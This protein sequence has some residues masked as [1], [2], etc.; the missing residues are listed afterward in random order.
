MYGLLSTT[1]ALQ[2]AFYIPHT[3]YYQHMN[4]PTTLRHKKTHMIINSSIDIRSDLVLFNYFL[5]PQQIPIAYVILLVLQQ[6]H[7][8]SCLIFLF[9]RDRS[10]LLPLSFVN[11][12]NVGSNCF[13]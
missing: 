12:L 5:T 1:Y 11:L 10:N 6:T 4:F 2:I 3:Y 7:P 13:F 9:K 8:I